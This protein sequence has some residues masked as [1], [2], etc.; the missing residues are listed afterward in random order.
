[1]TDHCRA[2]T[3]KYPALQAKRDLLRSCVVG[4]RTLT[5]MLERI[6]GPMLP[7]GC[8]PTY[9][10]GCCRFVVSLFRAATGDPLARQLRTARVP[11][12]PLMTRWL[13][14]HGVAACMNHSLKR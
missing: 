11:R 4:A 2:P 13:F 10:R 1:M 14:E 5:S 8:D 6:M 7:T 3:L 9:Q 12:P